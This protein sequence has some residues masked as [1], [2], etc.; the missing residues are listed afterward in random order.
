[1]KR[2]IDFKPSPYCNKNFVEHRRQESVTELQGDKKYH[3]IGICEVCKSKHKYKHDDLSRYG[4]ISIPSKK[5]DF[6]LFKDN[7][8]EQKL[9]L[10]RRLAGGI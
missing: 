3:A 2:D 6:V 9:F 10:N 1:M 5:R 4:N 7:K 8:Q